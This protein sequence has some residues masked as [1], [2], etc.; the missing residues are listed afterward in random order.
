MRVAR[1]IATL[2]A[3]GFALLAAAIALSSLP[4]NAATGAERDPRGYTYTDHPTRAS[5]G[6][7]IALYI[8]SDFDDD[9]RRSI[10][11][12]VKHWNYALNGFLQFRAM[13]L[14]DGA[15]PTMLAQIRRTGGWVP[16]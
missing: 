14:P 2:L 5:T 4:A 10:L 3:S 11:L 1:L 7:S 12:A 15:S 9:E 6:R 8:D 16:G 13:P